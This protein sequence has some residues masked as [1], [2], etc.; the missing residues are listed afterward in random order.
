[1]SKEVLVDKN[2]IRDRCL[3]L[4]F[5]LQLLETRLESNKTEGNFFNYCMN[6]LLASHFKNNDSRLDFEDLR[7][8]LVEKY[9]R[10]LAVLKKI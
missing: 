7:K 9:F 8:N 5:I 10:N 4:D 1:V 6:T 2:G 3:E